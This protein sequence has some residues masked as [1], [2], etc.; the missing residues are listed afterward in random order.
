LAAEPGSGGGGVAFDLRSGTAAF[1]W[2]VPEAL[3]LSGPVALH[4]PIEL[5]GSDDACLFVGVEKWRAGAPVPFEGSYGY[6][7]DRVTTGWLRVSHRAL[8]DELSRP[9]APVHTHLERRPP[10]AGDVVS[11]DVALR[12]SATRF[13][14]GDELRVV[15]RGRWLSP[16]DPIV[17]QFPAAYESSSEGTAIV[18]CGGSAEAHLLV[19]VVE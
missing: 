16:R 19:P 14:P 2:S 8:D 1:R 3:E 11:V 9:W 7:L 12:P 4:T 5:R 18:H 17:G 6:G 13:R 15:I 10:P